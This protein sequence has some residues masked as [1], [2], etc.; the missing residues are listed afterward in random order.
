MAECKVRTELQR[1][2]KITPAPA[3]KPLALFLSGCFGIRLHTRGATDNQ[4]CFEML[5]EDD[6]NWFPSKSNWADSTWLPNAA[7]CIKAAIEWCEKNG[8][9]VKYGWEA[10]F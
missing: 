2:E 3:G 9:K 1:D 7:A 6:T 10:K 5:V 4:I 8:K